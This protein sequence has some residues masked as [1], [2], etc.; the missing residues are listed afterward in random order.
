MKSTLYIF[1][2]AYSLEA[3]GH[4]YGGVIADGGGVI[5]RCVDARE[6]AAIKNSGRKDIQI[7]DFSDHYCLPGFFDSHTHFM[8]TGYNS[9]AVRFE[10]CRSVAEMKELLSEKIKKAVNGGSAAA[11]FFGKTLIGHGFDESSFFEKRMPVRADLDSVSTK[12]PVFISRVDHHSSVFNTAFMKLY[13]DFFAKVDKKSIETGILRQAPNYRIKGMLIND[14]DEDIRRAAYEIS[15]KKALA[16]GITSVCAL[17]GGAISGA[18]DV[19]FVDAAVKKGVN[20]LNMI[21]FDQSGDFERA[22]ELGL[23]RTGGC[24]LVDGSFGSRTAALS[25]PYAND[26]GNRGAMY[27]DEKFMAPF[28]EKAQ[29]NNL[30]AAFHAIGD[31]AVNRLLNCYEKVLKKCGGSVKNIMRH[32]IEHFEMASSADIRRAAELGIVLSMQPVF[33]TLW[34]GRNGM[35]AERLGLKRALKTN[36]FASII[37]AGAVIAGGSDSD[38]TAMSPLAGIH[39]LMNLP[40]ESERVGIFEAVSMFTKNGAYANFQERERG[41]LAAGKRA[42]LTIID[43]DIFTVPADKIGEI[44]ISAVVVDGEL[45]CVNEKTKRPPRVKR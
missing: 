31:E 42:D 4:F 13:P 3:P 41:S 19:Y 21:L 11:G 23:G 28:I 17:E 35:Y 39:A 1:R 32:R 12:V 16:A 40:N 5:R 25:S 18:N 6:A 30:Q 14:F 26:G 9:M 2:R 27:L 8:Q 10:S 7:F 37:R 36:R 33:E 20:K 15:E 38:V 43:S 24:L 22:A 29:M 44:K 45:R 34:G